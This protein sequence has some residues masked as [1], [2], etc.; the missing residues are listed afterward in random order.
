MGNICDG[1][2]LQNSYRWVI[3]QLEMLK[4]EPLF[5]QKRRSFQ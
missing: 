2:S 1:V 3:E 5:Y 4:K